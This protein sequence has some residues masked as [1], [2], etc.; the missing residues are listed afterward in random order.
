MTMG[1]AAPVTTGRTI[2]WARSYDAVVVIL[3]LGRAPALRAAT[4]ELAR[5]APGEA[6]LDVRCGTGDVTMAAH[7]RAGAA[8]QVHGID[9]APAMI[10]VARRKAAQAGQTI[11]Y[12]VAAVEALPF[13]DATV[14]VVVSSLMMHHLPDDLKGRGLA[15]MRRVLRPGGRLLVVDLKR[16]MGHLGRVT[17]PLLVHRQMRSG[18]QDLPTLV[19]AAGFISVEAGEAGF[20]PLG[21]VRGWVSRG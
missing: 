1:E 8:G 12:R 10:A 7:A 18:V 5:I 2:G 4:V 13:P 17:L 6:V 16:P 11:D 20:K 21:F 9:A 15:E 14:D 3:T 19:E